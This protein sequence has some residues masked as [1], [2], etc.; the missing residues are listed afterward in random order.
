MK[1]SKLF[2]LTVLLSASA[3]DNTPAA[4]TWTGNSSTQWNAAGNWT[5]GNAPPNSG[6]ALIFDG[7]NTTSNNNFTTTYIVN[8]ITFNSTAGAFSITGHNISLK[9]GITDN[10]TSTETIGFSST[11]N[12]TTNESM[13]V[14]SATGSLVLSSQWQG[15]FSLTKTGLGTLMLTPSTGS[16]YSAGTIVSAGTLIIGGTTGSATGTGSLTVSAGATLGGNGLSSGTFF[17]ITG[18]TNASTVLVGQTS[19]TDVNTTNSMT[20]VGSAASTFTNATLSYNLDTTSSSSNTLNLSSTPS[21]L[22]NG[23]NTLTFNLQNGATISNGTAYILFSDSTTG[24]SP[25]GGTGYSVNGSGVISGL[26]L[27]FDIGGVSTSLYNGS[28]LQLV[29]LGA[30]GYDIDLEVQSVPEPGTY[31]MLLGGLALLIVFQRSRRQKN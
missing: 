24:S 11:S 26:T 8:S 30:S 27:D 1:A 21:V 6:D 12:F 3:L 17:T 18:T 13:N 19:A 15:A 25:F 5:G 4:D 7:S 29:N 20:L 10:S 22:F 9:A 16:G 2:A 14:S 28:Y 23:T 31:A